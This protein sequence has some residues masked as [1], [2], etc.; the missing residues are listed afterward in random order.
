MKDNENKIYKYILKFEDIQTLEIPSNKILSVKEQNNQ[1][2]IYALIDDKIEP[3]IYNFA[4]NGTGNTITF[5]IDN[6][7]FL[8]TVKINNGRL[9][10]HVFYKKEFNRCNHQFIDASTFTENILECA[11]CGEE[12]TKGNDSFPHRKFL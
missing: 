4:I 8:G 5:D 7:K 6:F 9:M 2:V 12:A 11:K 1:I 3:I 10:F